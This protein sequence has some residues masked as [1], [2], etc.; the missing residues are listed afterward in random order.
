MA[1]ELWYSTVSVVADWLN[2]VVNHNETES[3]SGCVGTKQVGCNGLGG[4]TNL[5]KIF[6][7]WKMMY[8]KM[9]SV[10]VLPE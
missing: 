9:F 10:A 8:F 6:K 3:R 5:G 7:A 2:Q 4:D 1:N